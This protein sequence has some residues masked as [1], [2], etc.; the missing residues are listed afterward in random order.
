MQSSSECLRST[1]WEHELHQKS[2]R[3][4]AGFSLLKFKHIITI[5]PQLD[6]D[7]RCLH[8]MSSHRCPVISSD[9]NPSSLFVSSLIPHHVTAFSKLIYIATLK[10]SLVRSNEYR[11]RFGSYL[12]DTVQKFGPRRFPCHIPDTRSAFQSLAAHHYIS[13][14]IKTGL[15]LF[16][17]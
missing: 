12:T 3:I 16:H 7:A 11:S 4:P 13:R 14:Q 8:S 17:Q 15:D 6:L 5:L 1:T 9:T 2:W 10:R